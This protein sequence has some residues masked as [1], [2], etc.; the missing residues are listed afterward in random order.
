MSIRPKWRRRFLT[1]L[2]AA[3]VAALFF[4]L[5]EWWLF[6][7][8][9]SRATRPVYF[10]V[11]AGESTRLI[12]DRL[13]QVHLL[14]SSLGFIWLAERR[15]W[16]SRLRPGTYRLSPSESP[17][18]IL[19]QMVQGET[20]DQISVPAGVRTSEV[21]LRLLADHIGTRKQYQKLEQRPLPG[22]PTNPPHVRNALEGYLYPATYSVL[23]GSN[24]GAAI[25]LMWATFQQKNRSLIKELPKGWTLR[26]WVTLASIIQAEVRYPA[27]DAKVA[28]VFLNRLRLGMPLQS[29]ATVYYALGSKAQ[30]ALTERDLMVHSPYNTYQVRGL[31]PGP[32]DNPGP[33]A[34]WAVLHP[35]HVGYLYFITGPEGHAIFATTYSEQ[36]R[37][38]ARLSRNTTGK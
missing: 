21:V 30:G 35:A 3:I 34:L 23:R 31:P 19:A 32:I 27:D 4:G 8:V 6:G 13:T 24:A 2:G 36:L 16:A 10:T 1:G 11:Y 15:G 5:A 37:H 17:G 33:Q 28:A 20:V 29:D 14:H 9:D 12:A 25:S 26:R 7:S 18:L 38:I 22:M